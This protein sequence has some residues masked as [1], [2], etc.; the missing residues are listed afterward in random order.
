VLFDRDAQ[1][2]RAGLY[3]TAEADGECV[4][5]VVERVVS[6]NPLLPEHL[7]DS[8]EVQG[9]S[10]YPELGGRLYRR[11]VIRWL[12]LARPLAEEGRLE[13]P[14]VPVDPSSIVYE[15][16]RAVLRSIFSG[17]G[18]S[19]VK[20]GHLITDGTVEVGIDVNKLS[21]HLAILAVTG[22]GKSN[23]VCVL[24]RRIVGDLGGTLVVFDIH[25]EYSRAE[26][27]PGRQKTVKPRI[28]PASLSLAELLRL[29]RMPPSATNQERILRE[30]WKAMLDLYRGGKVPRGNFLDTLRSQVKARMGVDK[31]AANGV[32][33]RLDDVMDYYGDVLDE[34]A[35]T[36]LTSMIEPS[37][38]NIFD[39]S[40][41]DEYGADAV[42]SHYLRRILSERKKAKAS[43]GSDGYPV[44]VLTVI[45]EAHVFIPKDASTLTKTW[46]SRVAREGRKFGVG[47]ILVSQRPKGL[48]PD[49]LSQTNNKIILRIVEPTD[50]RYVQQASE[51]LSEDLLELLSDLNPGEAVLLGSMVRI[52][53]LVK[54]DLCEASTGGADIDIAREWER[55][56]KRREE[57]D[58]EL[59]RELSDMAEI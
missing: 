28:H 22:G 13:A 57:L 6:G 37:K 48:D 19:W 4:L 36:E 51:Q 29:T 58:A 10:R 34:S 44:P 52:P 43:G 14:R 27:V 42:V 56:A 54:I 16:P 55:W 40:E 8:E 11:G 50:Q 12:S 35:P 49:V 53:A 24:A 23:T 45:E 41:V 2:V 59:T 46:A 3:V 30:A 32:L 7:R 38:L 47:L 9:L 39:L 21:R 17:L 1:D 18:N 33:N 25:G 15:A 5:G 31:N 20:I 26:I